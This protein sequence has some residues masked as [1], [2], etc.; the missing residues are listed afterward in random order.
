MFLYP[1]YITVIPVSQLLLH[2]RA[3]IVPVV[4]SRT[5]KLVGRVCALIACANAEVSILIAFTCC[6]LRVHGLI[7]AENNSLKKSGDE[8]E[9]QGF[10]GITFNVLYRIC[11]QQTFLI[12]LSQWTIR[13]E[14]PVCWMSSHLHRMFRSRAL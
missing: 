4:Q 5:N 3:S 1:S 7:L 10:L 11:T 8:D 12:V 13:I 2:C 9:I 6:E 14:K